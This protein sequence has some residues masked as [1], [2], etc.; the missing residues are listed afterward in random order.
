LGETLLLVLKNEIGYKRASISLIEV[1][2]YGV[3][4]P[5]LEKFLASTKLRACLAA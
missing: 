2:E 1:D 5:N 4:M 3:V